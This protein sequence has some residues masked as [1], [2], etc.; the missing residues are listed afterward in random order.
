MRAAAVVAA[1]AGAAA[2][3][4]VAAAVPVAGAAAPGTAAAAE[5]AAVVAVVADVAAAVVALA[6]LAVPAV[7]G[8][9]DTLQAGYLHACLDAVLVVGQLPAARQSP[10]S[11]APVLLPPLDPG[12]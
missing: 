10:H 9:G 7:A 6:E 8:D 12:L 4:A 5:P 1:E 11:P 3:A 2:V